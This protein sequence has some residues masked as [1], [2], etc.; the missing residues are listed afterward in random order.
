MIVACITCCFLLE[1]WRLHLAIVQTGPGSSKVTKFFSPHCRMGTSGQISIGMG[2]S[3]RVVWER[4]KLGTSENHTRIH[5]HHITY[6]DCNS[7]CLKYFLNYFSNTTLFQIKLALGAYMLVFFHSCSEC[8]LELFWR[9]DEGKKGNMSLL[10]NSCE[11]FQREKEEMAIFTWLMTA[12]RW[13]VLL[14]QNFHKLCVSGK[15]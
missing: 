12:Q 5:M 11:Q 10:L 6:T 3:G 13:W 1:N 2:R 15:I 14:N 7:P 9:K 4:N 8:S